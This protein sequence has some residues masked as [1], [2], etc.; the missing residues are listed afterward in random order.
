MLL[1]GRIL[2]V[3][4]GLGV[5]V[6]RADGDDAGLAGTRV[7]GYRGIWFTL[8]QVSAFGDKYSGGLGTYTAN[9]VP[10]AVYAPK[11]DKT[12]FVYGGTT[13]A[14]QRH[15]LCMAGWYDH[16]SGEVPKPVVV[17]D[18]LTVNDPHDNPSINID[19]QGHLWVFVSGRARARPG[20][21]YRSTAPYSIDGFERV[22]EKEM[23]YPQLHVVPGKGLF[24]LFTKYTKGRELYWETSP[25]GRT[26]GG[27]S[28][29]AGMGGHYQVSNR[30]G[31]RIVTAFMYHPGGNVDRRTN[32]Y[33]VQ[34]SDMGQTWTTLDGEP[35]ATP[36]TD[37]KSSALLID[38]QA[39]GVNVYIHDLNFDR[40]GQPIILYLTSKG[41]APGPQNGPYAWRI[42]HWTG[43]AWATHDV[44]S[45]DHNYDTGSLYVTGDEWRVVG[46]TETGPQ[47]HG[48]G[49]EMA[50]W[51][52]RDRGATWRRA[53]T[54]TQGSEYN[55]SYARRP[56]D[57]KDP[58]FTFWADGDPRKLSPSRLYFANQA[59]DR[60]WQL[61][62]EMPGEGAKPVELKR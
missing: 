38:Y 52:S 57:A 62:Y 33:C 59:G 8:G 43:G 7:G 19:G 21:K 32:L 5:A 51:T 3:A 2:L 49:G 4:I 56:V 10:I 37:V 31:D 42:T 22:D 45:S 15:L 44:T 18:K 53:A 54:L 34:T 1:A 35:V 6:T 29:L 27:E 9:H 46:P 26:W 47:A 23:T 24:H 58:F 61:P 48:T 14:D 11:A 41:A 40:E 17:H 13:A 12:F 25:D 36:L 16:K 60:V 20:F 55:H 30:H 39:K 28:K 50:A